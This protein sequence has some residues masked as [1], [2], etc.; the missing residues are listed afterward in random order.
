MFIERR[1]QK[2]KNLKSKKYKISN[3]NPKMHCSIGFYQSI[4]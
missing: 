2:T 3:K 4:G 1:K